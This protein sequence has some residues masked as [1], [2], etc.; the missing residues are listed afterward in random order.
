MRFHILLGVAAT[1]AAQSTHSQGFPFGQAQ[2]QCPA[3]NDFKVTNSGASRGGSARCTSGYI[4]VTAST[5]KNMALNFELPKNQS[6][7][8][9]TFIEYVSSGSPFPKLVAGG[10]NKVSG[11]W[12]IGAT[13]CVPANNTTPK[14]VQLLTH[15]VGFDRY[16]WDFAPGYS[17][18]DVTASYGYATFF[19]DRLGIGA[20]DIA[21]PIKVIQAPLEV[22][23]AH[24]IAANLRNGSYGAS[25]DT[26]VGVG[27]SFGSI[28]TQ[29]ITSQYPHVLDAAILTGFSTNSTGLPLFLIGND[30]ALA[31]SNQP[32]RFDNLNNGFLVANTITNNQI[33][34]FRAPGFDPAVLALADATKGSVTFGELFT[35]TAPVGPAP[36]FTSPLAVVNGAEDLPF[37]SGNCSY[38]SNQGDVVKQSLYANLASSNFSSY[39]APTTG[40]GVNLHY[41]A[42]DSFMFIQTFLREHGLAL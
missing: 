23:I 31:N 10:S 41:S 11:T 25:F 32:Y 18:V 37:C 7:V 42:T 35:T 33:A 20:S 39:I 8:T 19:Y 27:H 22:E 16:Y 3:S 30:F 15:G 24:S 4:S 40:H 14:G 36:G 2:S 21:D 12:R 6:Q 26:V 13:L 5:D 29:S 34:F 1:A 28:I 38:P 9:E 17:Y